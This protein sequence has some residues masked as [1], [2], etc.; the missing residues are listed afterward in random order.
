MGNFYTSI[1]SAQVG[2][3][4]NYTRKRYNV[5]FLKYAIIKVYT[6]VYTFKKV[7]FIYMKR[8]IEKRN[9]RKL[10]KH[11]KSYALTI[12]IGIVRELG[13]QERQ[14]IVLKKRGKGILI[15]DWIG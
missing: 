9:I 8:T 2:K 11:S 12:P 5:N 13:W 1:Y 4:N 7:N 10:Y 3:I 15:E 6:R 14:K